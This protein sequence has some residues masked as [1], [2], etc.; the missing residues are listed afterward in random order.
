MSDDQKSRS[1]A[2]SEASRRRPAP[3]DAPSP[4]AFAAHDH[5]R[6]AENA[7]ATAERACAA[8]GVRLT[9]VR[10]RVLELLWES[11]R[12]V[13]AYDLLDRLKAE[14]LGSQPP[15]VYRAL[16][17]LIEQGFAHK[18]LKLNAYIGC[19]HPEEAH[20]PMF[21]ICTGCAQVGELRGSAFSAA[22]KEAAAQE[23]F[24]LTDAAIEIEGRCHSCAASA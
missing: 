14:N 8:R 23:A 7:V 9:P 11:H 22:L 3:S 10:R 1:A 21:L 13:S 4:T 6:C 2:V 12:P 18:L 17:F 20:S 16:D 19:T 24:Q 5:G 15:S